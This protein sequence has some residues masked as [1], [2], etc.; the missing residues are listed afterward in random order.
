MIT[1]QRSLFFLFVH[2]VCDREL[3]CCS[4]PWSHTCYLG[5]LNIIKTKSSLSQ[6]LENLSVLCIHLTTMAC[7]CF[8]S[9]IVFWNLFCRSLLL[10]SPNICAWTHA[11]NLIDW[12]ALSYFMSGILFIPLNIIVVFLDVTVRCH[13]NSSPKSS[14][15]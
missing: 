12:V 11:C 10:L 4:G 9:F 13:R 1:P 14:L 6:S 15:T 3:L 8:H 5:W 2:F 7:N